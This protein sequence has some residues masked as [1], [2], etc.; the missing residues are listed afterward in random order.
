MDSVYIFAILI[1]VIFFLVLVLA[2]V[3]MHKILKSQREQRRNLI[4]SYRSEAASGMDYSESAYEEFINVSERKNID[5]SSQL[6]IFD[7][8]KSGGESESIDNDGLEE[9][10][11]N[12]EG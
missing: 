10:K 7:I 5:E 9:I 3:L 12:Y 4:L 2:S 8:V 11:G 1:G 6:S